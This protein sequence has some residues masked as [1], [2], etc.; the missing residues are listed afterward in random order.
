MV[1]T[2]RHPDGRYVAKSRGTDPFYLLP[3]MLE[4]FRAESF[5]AAELAI[6]ALSCT[7]GYNMDGYRVV[8][9]EADETTALRREW[10]PCSKEKPPHSGRY[11]VT[12]VSEMCKRFRPYYV[13]IL[14]Y[15]KSEDEWEGEPSDYEVIAWRD[16]A[17]PY[18]V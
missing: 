4:I 12:L 13:D 5:E 11:E 3:E 15:L 10:C 9:E 7:D 2:I 16:T 1:Y 18:R 14:N 8:P 6:M 17:D